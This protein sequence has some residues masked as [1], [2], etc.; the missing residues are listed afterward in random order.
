LSDLL[1][2]CCIVYLD[3]ILIFSENEEEHVKH[4]KM[5]LGRLR[6]HRLYAKPSKC[7]FHKKEVDFLGYVVTQDGV[8][9]ELDRVATVQ[10][11]LTPTTVREVRVFL[12]FANYYRR[13]IKGYSRLANGL[14]K[15][16]IGRPGS[17]PG[18]QAQR[19]E[20]LVPI[21]LSRE[22]QESFIALK[23]AFSKGPV[24]RHFN[25]KKPTRLETDASRY[26][27]LGI[28]S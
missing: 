24:L 7:S 15:V 22:A 11:W 1:D 26:A 20:E 28:I 13:F 18:G 5:V 23:A 25:P 3:D 10:E 2:I 6:S 9:M 4:V 14:N 21:E 27:I 12:G 17:A 16:T 8:K 19:K